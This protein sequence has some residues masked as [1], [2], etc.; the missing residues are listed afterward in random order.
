ML[1]RLIIF[2]LLWPL[3]VIA[4]RDADESLDVLSQSYADLGFAPEVQSNEL[5]RGQFRP[6]N[7]T[8]LS[9][10]MDGRLEKLDVR[11]GVSVKEGQL[12]VRFSCKQVRANYEI[13][14]AREKSA[15]KSLEVNQKLDAYQNVSELELAMSEAE[16]AIASAEVRQTRAALSH[17]EIHAPF[18]ATVT[19]KFVQAH[20]YVQ[21]G[22]QLLEIVDTQNLEIEMVLPSL[23]VQGYAAG[24][25]FTITVDETGEQLPAVIDRI[26]NVIDPV[27]QTI[28]VIGRLTEPR[29][30]LMPGMSGN[31]KLNPVG[32]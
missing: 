13:S 17:C 4:A 11:P 2:I 15:E 30:G 31:V 20:Q 27:S 23:A 26:V 6:V 9:A 24:R 19:E 5:M 8:V 22:E 1:R 32:D 12:L 18:S 14:L 28:R 29:P 3:T 21:K 7:Y 16:L 10:G 25:S